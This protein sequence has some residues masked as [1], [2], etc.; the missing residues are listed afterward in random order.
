MLVLVQIAVCVFS[1][2]S[3]KF[4][5]PPH[6]HLR[7]CNMSVALNSHN[8]P[9]DVVFSRLPGEVAAMN[10]EDNASPL[11]AAD[12]HR[13]EFHLT[14]DSCDCGVLTGC[15]CSDSLW[16]MVLERVDE[17]D[18]EEGMTDQGYRQHV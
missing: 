11:T 12:G 16:D 7:H 3:T 18:M 15:R 8:G 6:F 17:S 10:L 5:S 1:H 2:E 4:T 14:A 13:A 9:A